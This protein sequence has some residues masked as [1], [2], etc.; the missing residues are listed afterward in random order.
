MN[1]L[2]KIR[3]IFTNE[4]EKKD[5]TIK[6]IIQIEELPSRLDSKINE[7]KALKERLK[8]VISKRVSDFETEA[9]E[10]I[11][12]LK[13]VDISQR[14]EYDRI[15]IIVEENLNLYISHLK[16][17]IDNI[18]YAEKE[19]IEEYINRLFRALN[20]FNRISSMPFEK[21]TILIGDELSSTRKIVRSF[22]QDINKIVEDNNLIFEK[23]RLYYAL[24][25]LLSKSRQLTLLHVETESK[26]TEITDTLKNSSIEHELLKSKLSEIREKDDFKRDNQEK[27]AYRKRL[28]SLEQDIQSI[29]REL[30]LKSLLKKFHHDRVIDQLVRNYVNDFRNALKEDKELKI[31]D[32]IDGNNE[33][34]FSQLKEIQ[35]TITSLCHFSPTKT[36]K[37]ITLLEEKMKEKIT[38]MLSL[39]NSM[40]NEIRRKEKLSI[41]LQKINSD[42]M[43]QS[44]FIF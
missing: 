20:E 21:A 40:T 18:K 39:E 23:C 34:Y 9:N 27:L 16:K 36:D 13:N 28:D 17:T 15:K 41:K 25:N 22:I 6:E 1:L 8:D 11:I 37:E 32:I 38:Y 2:N 26:I 4:Q 42:L 19:E 35:E 14:K 29:K 44:K 12:S 24:S 30:D 10:K 33:K 43:E 5:K 7:L 31:M 3:L